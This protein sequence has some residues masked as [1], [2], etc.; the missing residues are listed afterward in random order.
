[1]ERGAIR[2]GRLCTILAEGVGA[3]S[4]RVLIRVWALIR[5]NAV[6]FEIQVEN[7]KLSI[8]QPISMTG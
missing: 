3:Y 5:G 7:S 8:A 2:G 6:Y 1:M 4:E